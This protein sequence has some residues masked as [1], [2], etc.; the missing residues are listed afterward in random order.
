MNTLECIQETSETK[1]RSCGVPAVHLL[2]FL[3]VGVLLGNRPQCQ[4]RREDNRERDGTRRHRSEMS[5]R[6]CARG[7]EVRRSRSLPCTRRSESMCKGPTAPRHHTFCFQGWN[8]GEWSPTQM[9]RDACAQA[10]PTVWHRH[11]RTCVT[12]APSPSAG[13]VPTRSSRL[14]PFRSL[15]K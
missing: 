15:Y 3:V 8:T 11:T 1:R 10:P 5:T 14:S 6:Q 4:A 7:A 13:T 12:R 9:P 2:P